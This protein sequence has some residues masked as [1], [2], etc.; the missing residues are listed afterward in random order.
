MVLCRYFAIIIL[1]L[2]VFFSLFWVQFLWFLMDSFVL[3]CLNC[4][5]LP[6]VKIF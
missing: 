4:P 5:M 2:I 3:S 1:F 6:P